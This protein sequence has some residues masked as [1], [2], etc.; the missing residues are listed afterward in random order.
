MI[1]TLLTLASL[2]SSKLEIYSNEMFPTTKD[3]HGKLEDISK[4]YF[5]FI[6]VGT[7]FT[8]SFLAQRLSA[9]GCNRIL[10]IEAGDVPS[11]DSSIP[12]VEIGGLKKTVWDY[13]SV[14]Q[15][16]SGFAMK[17]K[18]IR[19][20]IPKVLGGGSILE[21]GAYIPANLADFEHWSQLGLKGWESMQRYSFRLSSSSSHSSIDAITGITD[22][23]L[24][25]MFY[26]RGPQQVL[27]PLKYLWLRAA[28]NHEQTILGDESKALKSGGYFLPQTLTYHGS[29]LNP[30]AVY[31]G[32]SRS[33]VVILCRVE[34]YSLI[35]SPNSI[36]QVIG[37][38]IRDQISGQI[39]SVKARHEV[40]LAGGGIGS[41]KVLIQSGIGPADHL[42]SLKAS[43]ALRLHVSLYIK[44]NKLVTQALL[45]EIDDKM[46]LQSYLES[47]RGLLA[48]SSIIGIAYIKSDPALQHPDVMLQL[49]P[50]GLVGLKKMLQEEN[51]FSDYERLLD[52]T[53]SLKN[54]LFL[55][56]VVTELRPLSLGTMWLWRHSNNSFTPRVNPSYLND[57]RDVMVLLRGIQEVEQLVMTPIMKQVGAEILYPFLPK[58]P[59]P[60]FPASN[61]YLECLLKHVVTREPQVSQLT[62]GMPRVM[63]PVSTDITFVT[64]RVIGMSGIRVVDESVFPDSITG[65]LPA[66]LL[67]LANKAAEIIAEENHLSC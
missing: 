57:R 15:K 7:G 22:K 27:K 14:P 21:T 33:N 60:E 3:M 51:L 49:K 54:N 43:F 46:T 64:Y 59:T 52:P 30:A 12:F 47:G 65:G 34:A 25:H 36:N 50:S 10:V 4:E 9:E 18:Q 41:P 58:C 16:S 39:F 20:K 23:E 48:N 44:V 32:K 29:K 26:K 31:L 28:A 55:E 5:D 63:P 11:F 19:M 24:L 2:F 13:L 56:M 67:A 35:F 45:E 17:N 38:R 1:P 53:G 62:E 42:K 8:G 40:I 37:V 6:I 66:T 61:A